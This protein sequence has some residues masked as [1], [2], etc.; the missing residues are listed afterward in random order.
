LCHDVFIVLHQQYVQ[1]CMYVFVG[2]LSVPGVPREQV[3]FL[4]RS[5]TRHAPVFGTP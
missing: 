3:A 1:H 2:T 4:V 5:T